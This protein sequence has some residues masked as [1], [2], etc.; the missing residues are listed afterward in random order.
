MLTIES[1]EVKIRPYYFTPSLYVSFIV[2]LNIVRSRFD[3]PEHDLAQ[4][5]GLEVINQTKLWLALTTD[6]VSL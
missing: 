5:I 2:D 4:I 1:A 3:D 6:E